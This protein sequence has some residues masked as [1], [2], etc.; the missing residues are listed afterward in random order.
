MHDGTEIHTKHVT[1][2]SLGNRKY[3]QKVNRG[4]LCT[5]RWHDILKL[6]IDFSVDFSPISITTTRIPVALEICNVD[7]LSNN[8]RY[9]GTIH[10]PLSPEQAI[11]T[12]NIKFN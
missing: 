1:K 6:G 5:V 11:Y 10:R 9:N 4:H 8:N 2:T 3:D 12:Y 7:F